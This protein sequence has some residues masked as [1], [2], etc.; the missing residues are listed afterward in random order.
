MEYAEGF[1]LQSEES[2]GRQK[3]KALCNGRL[4]Y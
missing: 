4:L 3:R 1:R 2:Q